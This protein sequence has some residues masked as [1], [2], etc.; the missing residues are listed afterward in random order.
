ME[1]RSWWLLAFVGVL[2]LVLTAGLPGQFP[3]VETAPESAGTYDLDDGTQLWPFT[4]KETDVATRTLPINVLVDASPART[5]A[6]LAGG[7]TDWESAEPAADA[8]TYSVGR[9]GRAAGADRYTAVYSESDGPVWNAE[10][11]QL[12]D[13]LYLGD[14]QHVRLYGPVD[15]DW[16]AIQAHGEHWDWFRLRHTVDDLVLAR[17]GVV[18]DLENRGQ[19]TVIE[20]NAP[21]RRVVLFGAA[22]AILFGRRL[23]AGAMAGLG[24]G[25]LYLGVRAGGIAIES[26]AV[27]IPPK[28][29]VALLYPVIV[30]GIPA[31]AY[32]STRGVDPGAPPTRS[33][34]VAAGAFAGI[35][36]LDGIA[37]GVSAPTVRTIAFRAVATLA[38][39]L[40]AAA[41]TRSGPGVRVGAILWGIAIAA[42]LWGIV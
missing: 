33:F 41:G 26:V 4:S 22:V 35:L 19:V 30:V 40:L 11:Y 12:A 3:T 21:P 1:R 37:M 14:R 10:R 17:D 20:R 16:T 25:A 38:V 2:V 18:D 31:L 7:S 13:G 6:M 39:G 36:V 5:R 42:P 15:G 23:S 8:E 32:L 34:A 29:I 27:G 24:P 9:W 28:A